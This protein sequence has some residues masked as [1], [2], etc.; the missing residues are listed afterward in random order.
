MVTFSYR[1][2]IHYVLLPCFIGSLFFLLILSPLVY[3]SFVP[4]SYSDYMTHQW[5]ILSELSGAYVQNVY[6][7]IQGRSP[8]HQIFPMAERDHMEDVK[9][10]FGLA[11][12]VEIV[13]AG[14]FLSVVL[15][16]FFQKKYILVVR[17][18]FRGSL[19]SLIVLL[20]IIFAFFVGFDTTFN[21]FHTLFFPQGNRS[22]AASSLLILLFPIGFFEAI[23][24]RIFS[25]GAGVSLVICIFSL[26][27]LLYLKKNHR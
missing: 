26:S 23:A 27:V 5:V 7:F 21:L 10:L 11:Y 24:T 3:Y 15:M 6:V 17:W 4:G 13:T 14:I 22:F 12:L 16:F 2:F 8:L 25:I 1:P 9:Q 20:S 19:L 18:L